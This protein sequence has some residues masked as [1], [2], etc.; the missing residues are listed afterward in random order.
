MNRYG[1]TL[2]LHIQD[3][4]RLPWDELLHFLSVLEERF[5]HL[6]YKILIRSLETIYVATTATVERPN[7]QFWVCAAWNI[8]FGVERILL[9]SAWLHAHRQL[10][11]LIELVVASSTIAV[12][13]APATQKKASILSSLRAV[14]LSAKLRLFTTISSKVIPY[15]FKNL[16]CVESRTLNRYHQQK[17]VCPSNLLIDLMLLLLTIWQTPAYTPAMAEKPSTFFAGK[18]SVP[19]YA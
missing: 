14:A 16:A 9:Q 3:L 8:E 1:Y 15:A 2:K 10:R 19:L 13:G 5:G 11:I 7:Q 4:I 17:H 18:R 12:V 6:I